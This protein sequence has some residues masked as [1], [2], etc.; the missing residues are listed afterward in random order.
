MANSNPIT[1]TVPE[2]T[3]TIPD[4]TPFLQANAGLSSSQV[5]SQI[6]QIANAKINDWL[7]NDDTA[8]QCRI[9]YTKC[10]ANKVSATSISLDVS[11][12]MTM[13]YGGVDG[14]FS[15]SFAADGSNG[16]KLETYNLST[17][18]TDG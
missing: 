5:Q 1:F 9:K 15:F 12:V 17:S 8:K 10:N 14:Y 13:G 11:V 7:E 6:S 2:E 4:I 18:Y 3:I 16:V